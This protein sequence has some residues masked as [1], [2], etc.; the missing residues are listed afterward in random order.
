MI[1]VSLPV[2]NLYLEYEKLVAVIE[3]EA[4]VNAYAASRIINENPLLWRYETVRLEEFLSRYPLDKTRESRRIFDNDGVLLAEHKDE[5]EWPVI[6][7]SFSLTDSG[8]VVGKLDISRSL[9]KI[10]I[11]FA[12]LLFV[13]TLFGLL[14][15][16]FMRMVPLRSLR[17]ML[18]RLNKANKALEQ[19]VI[20]EVKIGNEKD[21]MLIQQTKLAAMGEMIG[22]IAHQWRQPLNSV[23]L[24]I[25]DIN[26]A[27]QSGE[28]DRK[29]LNDSVDKAMA[30]IRYMSGTIDDFRYFY[31][32]GK[33]P[34]KFNLA[35]AVTRAI[36][37][38]YAS[39]Q[40]SGIEIESEIKENFYA[41]GFSN[42]YCQVLLNVINNAKDVL[43]ER[44]IERPK[45]IIKLFRQDNRI[46]VTV[47]DNGGGIREE[48]LDK[49]FE[50]YFSTKKDETGMGIGLYMSK[51]IIEKNMHGILG[52]T[53]TGDG[54]EFRIEV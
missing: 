7:R 6:T 24:I 5:L 19:R 53:N 38:V 15:Y 36:S 37:F 42:E 43:V 11:Q 31:K 17:E 44:E 33:E 4:E 52:V 21:L 8:H 22:N 39:F 10:V 35:E 3:T 45:V 34:E 51:M 54:A 30:I 9:R 16:Y 12:Y 2:I 40:K 47:R 14:T 26:K 20:E 28:L 29:Y 41:E 18:D 25:Q 27:E 13:S 49:I 23:G 50:P 1:S 32:P 46:V 48:I